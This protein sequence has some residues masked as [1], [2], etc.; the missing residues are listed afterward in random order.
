[1]SLSYLHL[2]YDL[3]S[4]H[5]HVPGL[6]TSHGEQPSLSSDVVGSYSKHP[7]ASLVPTLIEFLQS[8][9][10]LQELTLS[11]SLHGL[12]HYLPEEDIEGMV[13]LVEVA[14]HSTCITQKVIM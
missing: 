7:L 8:I 5:I 6:F 1:M 2:F 3:P 9:C 12:S 4:E 11:C 10:T 14:A 13:Q